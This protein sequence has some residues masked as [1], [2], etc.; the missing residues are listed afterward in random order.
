M[1]SKKK[2]EIIALIILLVASVI[3]VVNLS[4]K[5][6]KFYLED[7]Y[8]KEAKKEEINETDLENLIDDKESFAVFVYQEESTTSSNFSE[9]LD[10]FINKYNI[11]IYMI[12][13]S[14]IEDTVLEKYVKYYPS[15]VI[16][17]KGK[18]ISYLKMDS[19][20]DTKC[21]EN[22]TNFEDWFLSYVLLKY[23]N[24]ENTTKA[25][26]TNEDTL[27]Y[28][29]YDVIIDNV[30]KE[31]NKVNIYFFYGN[32]CPHCENELSFF[33][34]IED[35]YGKYYNLYIFEVWYDDYNSNLLKIFSYSMGKSVNSVPYT[36][37]G[38]EVISGFAEVSKNQIKNAII[39]NYN[40]D[41]DVYFDKILKAVE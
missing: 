33:D 36:I 31:D 11:T 40:E 6:E 10:E 29:K 37:I 1:I 23:D 9:V 19:D 7:T 12:S 34:E 27:T 24:D 4:K 25:T 26:T 20:D 14:S 16:L 38:N 32:G 5:D 30:T 3:L 2:I 15:F 21:F 18:V 28:T 22:L 8:Y 13:F 17:K 39:K 35:E 41:Y